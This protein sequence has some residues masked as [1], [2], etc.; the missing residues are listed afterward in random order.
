ME[1]ELVA[2]LDRVGGGPG[3]I[4]LPRTWPAFSAWWRAPLND[5]QPENEQRVSY[6]A[7]RPGTAKATETIFA[8]T[9]PRSIADVDLV[10]LSFERR[11]LRRVARR[12]VG[13]RSVALCLWYPADPVWDRLRDDPGWIDMGPSTP[14][15]DRFADG[16]DSDR[17]VTDFER[18]MEFEI[19]WTQHA[20]A[21][22]VVGEAFE[23]HVVLAADTHE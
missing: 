12:T 10:F 7:F 4:D 17:L 8:G 1:H 9:P 6:V 21:L 11:C 22:E 23:H 13:E 18:S 3:R 14:S 15:L 2:A 19:A 16:R 20:L 5:W